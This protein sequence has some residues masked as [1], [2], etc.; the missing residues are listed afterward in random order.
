M[1]DGAPRE[2]L[3]EVALREA[4]QADEDDVGDGEPEE[5]GAKRAAG[6]VE[7]AEAEEDNTVE[8]ELLEGAGV[9]HRDWG[10]RGGVARRGPGMEREERGERAEAEEHQRTSGGR[11]GLRVLEALG[12]VLE[13]CD[14]V[15]NAGGI[16]GD[17]DTREGCHGASGEVDCHLHGG[18]TTALATPEEREDERGDECELVEEVETDEVIG[19]EHGERATKHE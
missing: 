19:A 4:D 9:E 14:A 18:R 6:D 13:G 5:P 8:A 2:Q 17:Q 11:D 15:L 10:R 7:A 1:G 3:L 12:D 16:D